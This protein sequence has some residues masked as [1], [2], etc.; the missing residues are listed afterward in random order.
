MMMKK[1]MK[2]IKKVTINV[3]KDDDCDDRD[4]GHY[5]QNFFLWDHDDEDY[6]D[7]NVGD[8]DFDIDGDGEDGEDDE[9][10][11]DGEDSDDGGSSTR[12]VCPL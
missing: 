9:D 4:L 5:D 8:E 3:I 1:T 10:G 2:M 6:D 12:Q 11:D 7:Y